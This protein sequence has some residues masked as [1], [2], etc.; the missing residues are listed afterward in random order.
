VSYG[1][2]GHE[3]VWIPNGGL[4]SIQ[5]PTAIARFYAPE[6]FA[7]AADG[8]KSNL[9]QPSLST[10]DNQKIFEI[11][12]PG[13]QLAY[14][15]AGIIDLSPDDESDDIVFELLPALAE[16]VLKQAN[17]KSKTLFDYARKIATPVNRQLAALKRA[18]T[19]RRYPIRPS[20]M[21]E[22]GHT[23]LR[24]YFDGYYGGIESRVYVRFYH[25]NQ[26]L[27][28]PDV[29]R[30]GVSPG[31]PITFGSTI[32]SN[33]LF[34]TADPR[35]ARFRKNWDTATLAGAVEICQS[36]I[37]ACSSVEGRDLDNEVCSRIGGHIHIAT[38]SPEHGFQWVEGFRPKGIE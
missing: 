18:G 11:N 23:I 37:A 7:I 2:L 1:D 26:R 29:E 9:R 13:R 32:V 4:I 31:G 33:L 27:S 35:L 17:Q 34:T 20:P 12:E 3:S 28:S 22:R 21:A 6:G 14:S 25:E 36:Y 24:V 16:S 19:I 8:L 15:L 38:I 10:N 30:E 5:M